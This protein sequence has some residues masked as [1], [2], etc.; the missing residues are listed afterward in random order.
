M[1]NSLNQLNN[2]MIKH[3][4]YFE[5][6]R[7]FR[8][9]GFNP[10]MYDEFLTLVNQLPNIAL[11]TP[12][13]FK[14]FDKFNL[15]EVTRADFEV[16]V[17]EVNRR[18]IEKSKFCWHPSASNTTCNIDST[19]NIIVS[20]AHS[21]Q[22]NGVLSQIVE[23]GLVTTYA[24]NKGEFDSKELHKNHASIFWGFCNT[25]DAIFKPIETNS[26][27]GTDEQNFL[28]AYRGFVVST[29]KKV[30]MSDLMDYGVQSENDIKQNK[31]I[32]DD[33]ILASNYSILETEVFELP[34]FY[35]IAVS[36][37]FYLDFDFEKNPIPHSDDR[38]ED[39]F[40]TLLPFQNKTYFLLSY[41]K[42]DKHL[43]GNLGKQLRGRN[44]L[45]SDITML[46]AAH[47]E[48][49]YFNPTYY[50]TFIKKH[51]ENLNRIIF[52]TQMDYVNIDEDNNQ[53][54]NFSFTPNDYLNNP[55]DINFFG[56]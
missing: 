23:N 12:D 37:A 11:R 51:E 30:E 22:N 40:V 54:I 3:E 43:Y 13:D 41:F 1:V 47:T 15:T 31:K 38:M 9:G 55:L 20:A 33:A 53:T 32:F 25:H 21:I 39:I 56:Y 36:S 52:E 44:K 6:M 14:I 35:P 49:V 8:K 7:D 5:V 2:P 26:Y 50:N 27:T 29:H 28:F 45:K 4:R 42:Q 24:I 18:A 34:A 46:I 19:G 10:D 48:N 17:K 16:I